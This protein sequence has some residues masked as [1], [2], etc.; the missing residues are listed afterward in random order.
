MLIMQTV[1]MTAPLLRKRISMKVQA[2]VLAGGTAT[3]IGILATIQ[4]PITTTITII[5][6]MVVGLVLRAQL[7][8]RPKTR[9]QSSTLRTRLTSL[10][11]TTSARTA[12]KLAIIKVANVQAH[13]VDHTGIAADGASVAMVATMSDAITIIAA[14]TLLTLPWRKLPM[15]QQSWFELSGHGLS[16]FL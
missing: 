6:T 12:G 2:W 8:M 7:Q 4:V 5:I 15:P 10:I 1:M 9:I 13:S 11:S 14:S 3:I 16:K